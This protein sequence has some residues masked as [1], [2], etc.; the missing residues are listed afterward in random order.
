MISI[1]DLRSVDFSHG[2]YVSFQF[3]DSELIFRVPNVPY[4]TNTIDKVCE[5]TDFIGADTTQWESVGS[6]GEAVLQLTAQNWNVES[7]VSNDDICYLYLKT[8]V[9]RHSNSDVENSTLLNSEKFCNFFMNSLK[10]GYSNCKEDSRSYWPTLTNNF[11]YKPLPQFDIQGLSVRL[12]LGGGAEFPVITAF[13]SL[14]RAYSLRVT[15]RIS[16]LSY[17]DRKNPYSNEELMEYCD[18]LFDQFLSH[19]SIKFKA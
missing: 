7:S 4:N 9:I 17:S 16:A 12:D 3:D 5:L 18:G 14:G 2:D 8:E 15:L 10:E 1:S 6:D 19:V 11:F 13:L